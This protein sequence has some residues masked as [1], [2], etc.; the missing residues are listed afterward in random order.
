[1]TGL[2]WKL[3][4]TELAT[5]YRQEKTKPSTVLAD[6][7]ERIAIVDPQ[8]NVF[9]LLDAAGAR[10]SA[11]ESDLRFA[12][13]RP[14]GP[15]D[16]IPVTIKDNI[17]VEGLRCAWGS[18][19]YLDRIS[20]TDEL[21]VA[22]LRAQ[23]AV[24]L[25]KTNVSEF[26]L[27]RGNV[28][29]LAFGTTRNPW[30]PA[31]TSGA[32]TGGGSAGV[33]AGLGPVAFGTDGGGSIRRPSSY[34]NLVG[35][36]P[37]TGRV[38]RTDGLP[39]ILHDFEV[40]G[41]IARTVDDLA[42]ALSAIE[43]P[44][45]RDRL[46]FGFTSGA[47]EAVETG[48]KVLYVPHFGSWDVEEPIAR[49][50]AR[51]AQ[52]LAAIGFS[53]EEG[54]TPFDL[55]L[56]ETYWPLIGGSGLAWLLRDTD[57]QGR[58][59]DAYPPMIEKGKSASATD[60]VAALDAARRIYLQLM[61]KFDSYDLIMTPSAGGMPWKAED[62]GPAYHRV[63]TGFV[64]AAGLPAISIPCDPSEDGMPIGFQLIAPFGRDWQLVSIAKLFEETYPWAQRWPVI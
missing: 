9:A 16:G 41:P 43:G 47:F 35:L 8:L 18:K 15:F 27:G 49:S 4:A 26:T 57:W 62:H 29:T 39:A 64:N 36:K 52:Q 33:A 45:A 60:Y 30:N 24:I 55:D 5:A 6:I 40:I 44:D 34:N 28:N 31:K 21:P 63:F 13:G 12:E 20:P 56:F 38:A 61:E 46:S 2:L 37:S 11:A 10:K 22:R 32:S 19:L 14:L 25:G 7:L 54:E 3:S 51:A 59:G 42:M 53:V 23:G 50:C 48:L 17:E 58:I 1:M